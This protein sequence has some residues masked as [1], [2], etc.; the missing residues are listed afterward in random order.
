MFRA[1]KFKNLSIE[2]GEI[3][4]Y[5]L[6]AGG[7]SVSPMYK[8]T[9]LLLIQPPVWTS[10][11]GTQHIQGIQGIAKEYIKLQFQENEK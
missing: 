9:K 3:F 4:R 5:R 11:F 6:V 1:L 7:G 8:T 10:F 2:S